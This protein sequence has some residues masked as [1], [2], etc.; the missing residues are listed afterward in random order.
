M[1]NGDITNTDVQNFVD[2]GAALSVDKASDV[3]E[4]CVGIN[5][6]VNLILVRLGFRMPISDTDSLGWLTLTKKLGAT[7]LSLD[8]L[9]AQDSEEENTRAERYWEKYQLRI[10]ELLES[11]GDVLAGA[12]M[13]AD[14][15][16][17][18]APVLVGE[19]DASQRKRFLRFPQRAAADNYD[20][21][22]AIARTRAGW[23]PA[24]RGH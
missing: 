24:I 4:I 14:P 5:A 17:N 15:R 10:Q 20:N 8:L 3:D 1:A 7:A 6:D 22:I 18:N 23:R 16:P 13:Q 11:G 9:M 19:L 2:L 12:E 21:D